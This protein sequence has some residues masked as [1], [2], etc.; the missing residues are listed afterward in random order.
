MVP[1]SGQQLFR[2]TDSNLKPIP[3]STPTN[4][5]KRQIPITSRIELILAPTDKTV[6][7][8]K[9]NELKWRLGVVKFV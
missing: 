1:I 4:F 9:P 7:L 8:K 2:A 3:F 6:F 5:R